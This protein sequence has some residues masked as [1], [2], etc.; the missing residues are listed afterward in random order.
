MWEG[1]DLMKARGMPA[2]TAVGAEMASANPQSPMSPAWSAQGSRLLRERVPPRRGD[3]RPPARPPATAGS[4][5]ALFWLQTSR[6]E[7]V[8]LAGGKKKTPKNVPSCF[9][10]EAYMIKIKLLIKL[11]KSHKMKKLKTNVFQACP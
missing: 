4:W 6:N 3:S 10:V 1:D 9:L 2:N 5:E 11:G 8:F 7:I